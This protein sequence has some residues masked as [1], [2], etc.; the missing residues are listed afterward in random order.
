METNR[1]LRHK[2]AETQK[3]TSKTKSVLNENPQMERDRKNTICSSFICVIFKSK[4]L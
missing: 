2:T 3:V 4:V 1:E